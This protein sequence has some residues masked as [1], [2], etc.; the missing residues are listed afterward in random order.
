MYRRLSTYRKECPFHREGQKGLW[1]YQTL[2]LSDGGLVR[3]ELEVADDQTDPPTPSTWQYPANYLQNLPNREYEGAL[4][5]ACGHFLLDDS[6]IKGREKRLVVL[7]DGTPM[8]KVQCIAVTESTK[9]RCKHC[10]RPDPRCTACKSHRTK[11]KSDGEAE[12]P[13]NDQQEAAVK[14]FPSNIRR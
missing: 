9:Q 1:H 6:P 10:Y 13:G 8:V 7:E 2:R 5:S 12:Q 14:N 11:N 4:Y 3:L